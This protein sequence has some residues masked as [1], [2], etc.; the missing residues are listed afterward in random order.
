[1]YCVMSNRIMKHEFSLCKTDKEKT[2]RKEKKR[3]KTLPQK[4]AK[5]G[6]VC[7]MG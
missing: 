7:S 4:S 5:F 1:M 3:K 6:F 2:R